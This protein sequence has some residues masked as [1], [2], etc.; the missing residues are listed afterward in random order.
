MN[1]NN[2]NNNRKTTVT[3]NT[4]TANIKTSRRM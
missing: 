1:N 4:R 2:N 3:E